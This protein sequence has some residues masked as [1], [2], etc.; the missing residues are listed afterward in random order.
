MKKNLL[1][2]ILVLFTFYSFSQGYETT[3]YGVR[4]GINIS[5]LDFEPDPTFT[6]DHRNGFYF[7]GFAEFS[8]SETLWLN[9]ELQW[10]AEGA[11]AE[12]IR[13]NYIN[14]PVQLRFQ[15]FENLSFGVGPQ[16]GIKTWKSSD[17]FTNFTFSGL[18][19]VEY[20]FWDD[21]FVD[22]RGIYGFSNIL[23][24]DI[25]PQEAKQFVIQVGVGIKI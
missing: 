10:S 11:K 22:V 17:N 1:S 4:A 19:G 23:D 5:N 7:G 25:A 9:T 20:K 16:L 14:I 6:D 21:Y 24:S 3:K 15:F 13:A 18:G 2:L 12:N 8:L